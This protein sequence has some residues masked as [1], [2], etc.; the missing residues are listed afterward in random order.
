MKNKD[1]KALSIQELNDKINEMRMEL[2]KLKAQVATG[3][4]LKKPGQ[5]KQLKK[6]VARMK[7]AITEK[8]KGI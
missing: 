4:T 5:I 3:T 6:M 2:L 1:I 8:S 7:T